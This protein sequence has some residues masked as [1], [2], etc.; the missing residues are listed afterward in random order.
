MREK[1]TLERNLEKQEAQLKKA[2]W[3]LGN[4]VFGCEQDAKGKME[5]LAKSKG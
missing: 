2:I 1:K 5:I 3:H 4:E